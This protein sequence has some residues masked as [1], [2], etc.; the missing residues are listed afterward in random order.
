MLP[1]SGGEGALQVPE[2]WDQPVNGVLVSAP[3]ALCRAM[4][5]CVAW[6]PVIRVGAAGYVFLGPW[7]PEPPARSVIGVE[8]S[9]R[10]ASRPGGSY[11]GR[12]RL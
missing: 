9:A 2:P 11:W 5:A 7:Y 10:G 3:A 6:P 4:A 1:I 12:A 8:V